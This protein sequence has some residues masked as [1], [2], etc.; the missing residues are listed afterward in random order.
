VQISQLLRRK[1][2]EVATVPG[3]TSVREALAV[4]ARHGIGALVVSPDGRQVEGI[5]SERDV[6]RGLHE[7]GAA[8]LAEP[9]SAVMTAQVHTCG[10]HAGVQDLARTMTDHRVRHVPVVEDGALVGIVSIGDV[11]KA[12]L[13][14]LEAERE[15]LV[16]YIQTS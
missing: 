10:P 9:V 11:V 14:E 15:Q 8:F 3:T 6:A 2:H 5:V 7:R 4:L 12:R 16:D 13:D 1:G